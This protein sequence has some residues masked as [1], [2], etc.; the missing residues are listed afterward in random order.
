[1]TTTQHIRSSAA[2]VLLVAA[3]LLVTLTAALA[4]T[5][6]PLFAVESALA[7]PARQA[8]STYPWPVKPF[9]RPH[10]IRGSFG[11]PRT[12]FFGPPTGRTLLAGSGSFTFHTGVDISALDGTPVYPVESGTVSSVSHDWIAVGSSGRTFQYWHIAPLVSVGQHVD[13]Q[14]TVLGHILRGSGH[15][16]LTEIDNGVTVNPLAPGHLSPYSDTTVPTVASVLFRKNVTGSDQMPDFIR[17][18]VELLASVYDMPTLQVPGAWRN[19]PVTPALVTWQIARA[20]TGKIVVPTRIAYDVRDHLPAA[21]TFWQVYARGTHQNM[22]VFG[23]HYSYMQPG[24]YLLRLTPGGFDTRKLTD[25]V[26]DLVVTATDIRGN[27][28][29]R[30]QR[31]S[32]HNRAGVSGV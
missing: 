12:L 6:T 29:S 17:G 30:V 28:S 4:L 31:F 1:M 18:S 22:A 19:L 11:D 3:S 26:Y 20:D 13:A 24:T 10:P 7:A 9:D 25:A 8:S 15:V 2:A 16:H 21:S 32:V 23:K 27:H 14:T 5:V